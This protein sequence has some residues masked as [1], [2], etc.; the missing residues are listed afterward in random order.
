MAGS[1]IHQWSLPQWLKIMSM[2]SFMPLLM[3]RIRQRYIVFVGAKPGIDSVIIGSGIPVIG[4]LR[5]LFSSSGIDPQRS[6]PK[7]LEI[8]QVVHDSFMSPP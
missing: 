7:I 2:M 6:D 8:I 1:F 5:L 4:I 3:H